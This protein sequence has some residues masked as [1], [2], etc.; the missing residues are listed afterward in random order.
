[1]LCTDVIHPPVH[2]FFTFLASFIVNVFLG[3]GAKHFLVAGVYGGL[4]ARHYIY[5]LVAMTRELV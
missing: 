5:N 3:G 2:F 1:V 4:D